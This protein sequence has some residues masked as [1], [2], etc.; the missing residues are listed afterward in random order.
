MSWLGWFG[1][2][3]GRSVARSILGD[4]ADARTERSAPEEAVRPQTEEEILAAERRYDAEAEAY[5]A[6]DEARRR[7]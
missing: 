6:E 2:G 7:R 5:R 3:L 1:Y 4:G